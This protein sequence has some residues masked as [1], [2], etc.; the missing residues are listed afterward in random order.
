MFIKKIKITLMLCLG[1]MLVGC[2]STTSKEMTANFGSAAKALSLQTESTLK[3][4]RVSDANFLVS[5]ALND[6][7]SVLELP[8]VSTEDIG[9]R[10]ALLSEIYKYSNALSVMSGSNELDEID[11]ASRNLYSALG[12]LNQ[13]IQT[14]TKHPKPVLND[15]ALRLIAVSVNITGRMFFE[16][17]RLKALRVTVIK[18]DPVISKAIDLLLT[19]IKEDGPWSNSLQLSLAQQAKNFYRAAKTMKNV[20]QKIK[21]LS[22]AQQ[23]YDQANFQESKFAQLNASLEALKVSHSALKKALKKDSDENVTHALNSL[24]KLESK[25]S[26][27]YALEAS[28]TTKANVTKARTGTAI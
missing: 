8:A 13:T 11:K 12:S 2:V 1:A 19:E 10:L 25:I 21:L 9:L 14:V 18:A 27:I 24:S 4:V 5:S 17:A 22:K 23:L 26:R 16:R 20:D 15:Q 6:K 28:L 7:N 3:S